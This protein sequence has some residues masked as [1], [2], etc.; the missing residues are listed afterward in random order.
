M[1]DVEVKDINLQPV[2][3]PTYYVGVNAEGK[4]IRVAPVVIPVQSVVGLTGTIS[5]ASLRSALGLGAAAYVGLGTTVNDAAYGNHTHSP[6]SIGAEPSYGAGTTS[7]YLRGDKTW[8][9]LNKAAVGLS[10]VDN[11]ADADKPISSATATALS[12]KEPTI[13]S[14][15]PTQWWRGDKQ[16]AFLAKTDVGLGSVDN[17]SDANKPVSTA[18]QTALGGK[19]AAIQFKKDTTSYGTLGAVNIVKFTG[20]GV[21]LS[22]TGNELTVTVADG[23]GAFDGNLDANLNI[24]GAA[25]RI[26]GDFSNATATQRTLLQTN[27]TNSNSFVGVIPSGT[28]SVGG[29]FVYSGSDPDNAQSGLLRVQG[30][31]EVS[32]R[33]SYLGT[34]ASGT[35]VPLRFYAGNAI[36][37]EILP[38]KE[39]GIGVTP[40]VGKGTVQ[41][42][43]INGGQIAGNRRLNRNGNFD[44]WQRGAGPFTSTGYTAD[45]WVAGIP[46]GAASVSR[47]SFTVGDY[48]G[49]TCPQYALRWNQTSAGAGNQLTYRIPDI[50]LFDAKSVTVSFYA[51]AASGSV[52]ATVQTAQYFGTGGSS[53]ASQTAQ[54]ATITTT[55]TKFTLTFDLPSILGKTIGTG[56][57]GQVAINW[58]NA[59]FD[60]YIS[61]FQI[62]YGV[63]ATPFEL[64][65]Q[66]AEL[67]ACRRWLRVQS[68]WVG[69]TGARTCFTI[70]M[71]S[72]PTISGGGSGFTSTGTT[73][74]T[75][76]CYQTT[77]SAQ[78]LT[79]SCEV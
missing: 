9:T 49:T 43:D 8:Q 16:W 30:G 78:T 62:E 17:T 24:T 28:A 57:Y 61:E 26:T 55:R 2:A 64:W 60:V 67:A 14:G 25:R 15:S 38:T 56:A 10:A 47:S 69:V 42:P 11:T 75:L 51:V 4:A 79:L 27:G 6:A 22:E 21:T 36:C 54:N 58:P 65:D 31:V 63:V 7:Q 59:T 23:A 76:M 77:A 73:A 44:I 12:G 20:A 37:Q 70:D 39:V 48:Y 35:F 71:A 34:P 33:S 46:A 53:T 1:A 40:L 18:T 13:I 19:N 74:D 68:V 41:V 72:T 3:S 32:V 52:A 45:G 50:R 29:V 5:Q 66:A